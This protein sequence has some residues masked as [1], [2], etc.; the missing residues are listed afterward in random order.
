MEVVSGGTEIAVQAG[1]GARRNLALEARA[2]DEL[3]AAPVGVD[4]RL[5]DAEIVG[6][7]GVAHDDEAPTHVRYGVDIGAAETALRRL[8]HTRALGQRNRGSAVAGTV[9][10][11]DLDAGARPSHA[12]LAPVDESP[13]GAL[14]IERRNQDRHLGIGYVS[15]RHEQ[16]RTFAA[17]IVG[18]NIVLANI[19]LANIVGTSVAGRPI[20]RRLGHVAL[21]RK[22]EFRRQSPRLASCPRERAARR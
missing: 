1:H 5:D 11:E 7:V 8:E 17:D 2:H 21:D 14:L 3:G 10:D 16:A 13:N 19:V 20:G 12:L 9:H 22:F 4:I 6:A 15:R 18:A